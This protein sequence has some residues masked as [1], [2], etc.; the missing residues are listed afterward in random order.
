M[1]AG[2]LNSPV[3]IA[4]ATSKNIIFLWNIYSLNLKK[5]KL[6]KN[7]IL[8]INKNKFIEQNGTKH[9]EHL[10]VDTFTSM[11]KRPYVL[12][13]LTIACFLSNVIKFTS[14]ECKEMVFWL[15]SFTNRVYLAQFAIFMVFFLRVH[16]LIIVK[17]FVFSYAS[18]QD[19]LHF[20]SFRVLD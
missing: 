4:V 16:T 11:Q 5:S 7:E 18:F 1:I 15:N 20:H 6:C 13:A 19:R 8:K 2:Y 12:S 10:F 17:F 14:R 9:S 3:M